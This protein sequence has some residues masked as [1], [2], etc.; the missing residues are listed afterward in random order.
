MNYDQLQKSLLQAARQDVPSEQVPLAFERRIMA[1]L[2]TVPKDL[3]TEWT[4][5]FWRL[6]LP[7]L[8]VAGV[9]CVINFSTPTTLPDDGSV[10]EFAAAELDSLVVPSGMEVPSESW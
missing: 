10:T 2:A 7:S 9:A 4:V 1:R 5:A 3:L 8:A 6:A